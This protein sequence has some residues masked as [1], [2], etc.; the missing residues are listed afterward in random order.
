VPFPLAPVLAPRASP[1][2]GQT[3]DGIRC[4][5]NEQV[6]FH[7]HAHLT[8]FVHGRQRQIP[9]GI[10]IGTPLVVARTRAG[11]F[12]TGGSCFSWLHTHAVDGV[13]HI[14]SPVQRTYTLGQFFDLWREP[15]SPT[16]VG[17]AR[18]RVVA[19]VDGFLYRG[20]PRAIALE[21]QT[22]VQLDVGAPY[23]GQQWIV[24]PP[25]L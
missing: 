12:V 17:P 18:G 19:I 2:L 14:E 5:A 10:G 22:Q 8:L 1:G 3:V 6:L 13:I 21:P 15:L 20:S 4:E 16:Q 25:G 7:I 24:F 11:P 23:V 9:Y